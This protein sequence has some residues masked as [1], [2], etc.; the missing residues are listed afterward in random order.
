L[1][2]LRAVVMQRRDHFC[3]RSRRTLAASPKILRPPAVSS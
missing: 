3:K 1:L 2:M